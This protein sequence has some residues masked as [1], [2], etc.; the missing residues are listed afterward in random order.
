M[1]DL[2]GFEL[3][4][5]VLKIKSTMPIILCSGY[6]AVISEKEARA[7]GIRRYLFKPISRTTLVQI[8]RQ[9]LD[10]S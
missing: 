4:Q 10:E 5:E 9:V 7:I 1:P 6:S 8:V 3:A 2:T